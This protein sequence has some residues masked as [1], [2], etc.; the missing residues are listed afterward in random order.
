[1]H[2]TLAIPF[3]VVRTVYAL[4]DTATAS[5]TTSP[6]SP[7][8]G[9]VALFATMC[10]LMEYVTLCLYMWVGL[11]IPRKKEK[12]GT[13]SNRMHVRNAEISPLS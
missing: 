6:W 5:D 2:V 4:A 10:L 3:L 12:S 8:Y 11:S 1:M 7:V 13:R 9:N